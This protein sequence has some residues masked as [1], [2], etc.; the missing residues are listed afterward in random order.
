MPTFESY[1]DDIHFELGT[2]G[3]PFAVKAALEDWRAKEDLCKMALQGWKHKV[4]PIDVATAFYDEYIEG[5]P[6]MAEGLDFEDYCQDVYGHLRTLGGKDR[7]ADYLNLSPAAASALFYMAKEAYEKW[8]PAAQVARDFYGE[9]MDNKR[10]GK[11]HSKLTAKPRQ[12]PAG[13][14]DIPAEILADRVA[15]QHAW[16]MARVA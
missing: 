14:P 10:K 16:K 8:T 5:R 3:D 7:V 11:R 4:E 13:E 1:C 15:R 12:A 6:N 2:M 9:C